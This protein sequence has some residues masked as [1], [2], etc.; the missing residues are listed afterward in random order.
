MPWTPD[1]YPPAMKN[2]PSRIRMKAIE[3]A[4]ALLNITR[5]VLAVERRLGRPPRPQPEGASQ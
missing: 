4:D 2:L 5:D 3:I 1:R